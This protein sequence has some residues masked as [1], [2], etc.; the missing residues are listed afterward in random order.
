MSTLIL[1]PG[2]LLSLLDAGDREHTRTRHIANQFHDWL[3]SSAILAEIDY[4]LMSRVGTTASMAFLQ[5]LS[6]GDYLIETYLPQDIRYTLDKSSQYK[7]LSLGLADCAVM[8]LSE[9][10]HVPTIL[11]FDNH[12]NIV[13]PSAFQHFVLPLIG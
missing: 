11:T 5:G 10:L 8:A 1:D 9:R 4:M 7:A 12:F 2:G 3:I 6:D 13:K